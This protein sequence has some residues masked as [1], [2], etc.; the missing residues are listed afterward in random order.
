MS[1]PGFVRRRVRSFGWAFRGVGH[2]FRN[3]PNARIHALAV[4]LAIAFAWALDVSRVEWAILALAA[5]LV[6]GLEALNSALEALCDHV[7]KDHHPLVARCKDTAA[8]A[9]LLGAVAAAIAGFLILGPP[10]WRALFG[11]GA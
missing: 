9:V 2:L 7:A 1:E 6:L 5:G 4:V 3:E 8:G 11:A 10:L